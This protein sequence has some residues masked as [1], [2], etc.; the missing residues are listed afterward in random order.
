MYNIESAN[1][2]YWDDS[3]ISILSDGETEE[4]LSQEVYTDIL[5]DEMFHLRADIYSYG[6]LV[7]YTLTGK[8]PWQ[9]RNSV[10]V[11]GIDNDLIQKGD[12]VEIPERLSG[13][14][15]NVI[16][17]CRLEEPEKR[18]TAETLVMHYYSGKRKPLDFGNYTQWH[19]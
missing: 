14:L 13:Q 6:Q 4:Q 12:R 9:G 10:S 16:R 1:L 19:I 17:D 11:K 2:V 15:M 18:P 3:I 7:A 8:M 5:N